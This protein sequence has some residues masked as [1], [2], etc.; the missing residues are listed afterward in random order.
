[1]KRRER[2]IASDTQ[3]F[4]ESEDVYLSNTLKKIPYKKTMTLK[5]IFLYI[6]I[7]AEIIY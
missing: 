4:E 3:T 6:N 1:M 7:Y 5:E 2:V